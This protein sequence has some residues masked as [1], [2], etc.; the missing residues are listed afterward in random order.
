MKKND[1]IVEY[2]YEL[3]LIDNKSHYYLPILT[4]GQFENRPDVNE[5]YLIEAKKIIRS[6]KLNRIKND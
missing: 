3:Y 1:D 5:D 4:F 2:A 6:H